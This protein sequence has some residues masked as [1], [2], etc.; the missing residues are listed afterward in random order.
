MNNVEIGKV[1]R[2]FKGNY[3]FVENIALDSETMERVVV[4]KH[5]SDD[6]L[7]KIWT[8]TESNFLGEIDINRPDNLTKQTHRFELCEDLSKNYNK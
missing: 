3:F 5:L 8:R 4:Y 7:S 1:Y 2:H 6:S